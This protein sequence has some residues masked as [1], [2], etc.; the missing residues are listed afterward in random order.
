M[1]V[2]QD[3][4]LTAEDYRSLPESNR[5]YELIQGE[6][7]VAPAP[8][9]HHQRIVVNLTYLLSHFL[10]GHKLGELY[11]GPFDVYLTNHDVLQPDIVYVGNDRLAILTDEGALGAPT[12]VVEILSPTTAQQ[13]RTTKKRIYAKNGVEELWLVVPSTR[14]VE[15]YRLQQ[16]AEHPVV[17]YSQEEPLRSLCFPG[18]QVDLKEVF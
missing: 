13:D 17:I 16:D 4:L 12:L 5:R 18:L 3:A 6:L 11:T 14:T 15:L 8:N 1:A 9:R 2:R 7:F 10:R